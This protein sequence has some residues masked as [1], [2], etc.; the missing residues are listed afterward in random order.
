MPL[1][2]TAI[3]RAGA[4]SDSFRPLAYLADSTFP[5]PNTII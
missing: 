1:I 2:V 3:V 4:A 5:P